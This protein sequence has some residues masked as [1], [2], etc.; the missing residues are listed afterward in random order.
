MR[1]LSAEM[2]QSEKDRIKAEI[3]SQ[4]EVVGDCWVFIP[5]G[6]RGD[7]YIN[8]D[9]YGMF[10][11]NGKAHSVSRILLAFATGAE[12]NCRFDACHDVHIC[13]YRTCCNPRHLHWGTKPEN[14]IERERATR[15]LR[16]MFGYWQPRESS[17]ID[18]CMASLNRG[19]IERMTRLAVPVTFGNDAPSS[20]SLEE[21]ANPLFTTD[22]V[23]EY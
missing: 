14:S 1:R 22:I 9:G 13:T 5:S 15:E 21:T 18:H 10:S 7:G 12:L 17:S 16:G 23:E 20:P 3:L 2:P 11:V 4:C 8:D 19:R 6:K